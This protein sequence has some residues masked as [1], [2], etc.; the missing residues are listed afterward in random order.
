MGHISHFKEAK[1]YGDILVVSIT[2]DRFVKKG[3][4]KPYFDA[5]QRAQFLNSLS[6]VDYVVVNDNKSSIGI[7]NALKPA[8]YCKGPDY[9]KK[10]GDVAG[11]L[12]IEKHAV[13]KHGGKLIVTRG[14]LYSS[15]K[16]LNNNF[17]DFNLGKKKIDDIYKKQIDKTSSL[18][19]FNSALNKARKEKILVIGEIIFDVYNYSTP[20]GTPSKENILSVKFENKKTYYGGTIPVVNTIS[21]ISKDVTFASL[22]KSK[23]MSTILRKNINK[24][25]KIKFFYEKNFKEIFKTRFIDINNKK[26]FF[27]YYDFNNIQYF[28]LALKK[29]LNK[30][31]KKFDKV[32]ICDFGHGLF[33]SEI[34]DMIQ[35]KAKFICA[36]IQT[37]SGN[38]GY[39]LFTK[40]S[41]LDLLCVDEPELRL[42]LKEKFI[43][44]NKL[45]NNKFLKNYKN[46]I[47]TRSINGLIIKLKNSKN[48]YLEFPALNNKV[49]DTMGAG[50]AVYSY[51]ASLIKNTYD[52]KI[53]AIAGSIA[54]AIKTNILGHSK[55]IKIEDIKRSFD[56]ILK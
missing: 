16:I 33:N 46:I 3:F 31:L 32:I 50:D 42:G 49:I 38:R 24:N 53:I 41:K 9:S 4:N 45:I 8:A 19:E 20:L 23:S 1:S 17:E 10:S 27:E 14:K 26:K 52:Q 35:K 28:N 12:G 34:V 43:S 47:V 37:N 48:Q 55:N 39:N 51:C 36:N 7:I 54:G 22:I 15:T 30:N 40:Y 11:N 44:V 13:E 29:Y 2:A 21:E 18:K 6:I 56:T 5:Y 25:V